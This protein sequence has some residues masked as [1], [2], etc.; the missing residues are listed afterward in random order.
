MVFNIDN[1][2]QE[3]SIFDTMFVTNHFPSSDQ[4]L[5]YKLQSTSLWIYFGAD[6]KIKSS[7]AGHSL[8]KSH[9]KVK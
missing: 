9:R 4:V 6:M 2:S 5:W 7:A 8:Q 1:L 3:E